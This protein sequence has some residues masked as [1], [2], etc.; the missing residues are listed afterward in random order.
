MT[1]R[2]RSS[3]LDQSN[4]RSWGASVLQI[5]SQECSRC[6]EAFPLSRFRLL[7][8]ETGRRSS[9][10]NACHSKLEVTRR[11][12]NRNKHLFRRT[13]KALALGDVEEFLREYFLRF[14]GPRNFAG[15]FYDAMGSATPNRKLQ[16]F[17]LIVQCI[18]WADEHQ[19]EPA[20]LS[21]QDL[22]S[23]MESEFRGWVR[24]HPSKAI[25][26]LNELGYHIDKSKCKDE[27]AASQ[28]R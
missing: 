20:G 21:D 7:S 4:S 6:H 3:V 8:V 22:H 17:S 5:T 28:S 16:A 1:V 11:Q 12:K 10:C 13:T 15:V 26:V 19:P 14:K 27:R 18:Q 23:A 2:I 25:E 24:S 9:Y